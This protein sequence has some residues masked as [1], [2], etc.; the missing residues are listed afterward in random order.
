MRIKNGESVNRK[1]LYT[2]L[3]FRPFT[4]SPIHPFTDKNGF[5]LIEIIMIILIVSIAIPA[6]LIM[7]GGEAGRGVDA[8]LRVTATNVAQ[9]LMEE[10][11]TKC[12][13][14]TSISGSAC[15]QTATPST[16]LGPDDGSATETTLASYDDVDDFNDLAP[17]GGSVPPCTDS[18]T[19]N[20]VTFTRQ[21][22]VCYVNPGDLNTCVDNAPAAGSCTRTIASGSQTDYKRIAV[23]VSSG[24]TSVTLTTVMTN[25]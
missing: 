6:L 7:L 11:R 20:N 12:W 5:S 15:A 24:N 19:V 21:T 1:K 4:H 9:Q 2:H 17:G 8:E 3:P 16:S 22:Q 10:I 13:D 18:V 25:Y 14:E 23:T